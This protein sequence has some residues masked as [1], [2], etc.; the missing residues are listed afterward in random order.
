MLYNSHSP[1]SEYLGSSASLI[2]ALAD[3]ELLV[4][5]CG[6]PLVRGTPSGDVIRVGTCSNSC[7]PKWDVQGTELEKKH[8]AVAMQD[9]ICV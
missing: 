3:G 7:Q 4:A 6:N 5:G 9:Y 2:P 8:H 1:G